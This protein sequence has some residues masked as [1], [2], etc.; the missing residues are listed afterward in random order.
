MEKLYEKHIDWLNIVLS[1]GCSD[2]LAEDIVQEMYLKIGTYL[3]EGK[4]KLD[5]I[6][7]N[8][9]EVNR[10]Y[11]MLTLKSIYLN[12]E[13][14]KKRV[15]KIGLDECVELECNGTVKYHEAYKQYEETLEDLHWY[16]KKVWELVDSGM[17]ISELSRKTNISYRSLYNTK[18][19]VEKKLRNKING[20]R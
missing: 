5:D 18:K 3:H 2:E 7:Y 17:S 12:I 13:K 8:D 14:V 9:E 11:V 15:N 1:F 10:W 16:D 20:T 6:M 19:K 4:K